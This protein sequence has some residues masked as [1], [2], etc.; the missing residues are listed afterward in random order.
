[1]DSISFVLSFF[2]SFSDSFLLASFLSLLLFFFSLKPLG[3]IGVPEAHTHRPHCFQYENQ[4][5]ST[6]AQAAFIV[7]LSPTE[8]H[9]LRH[10]WRMHTG[11]AKCALFYAPIILQEQEPTMDIALNNKTL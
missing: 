5:F 2:L 9:L 7:T 4:L 6:V 11:A 3:T 10:R 1:M 8:T